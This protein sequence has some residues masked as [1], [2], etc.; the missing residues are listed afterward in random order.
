[1]KKNKP[2]IGMLPLYLQD[3]F[4]DLDKSCKI[5]SSNYCKYKLEFVKGYAMSLCDIGIISYADIKPII[6]YYA[7]VI[8]ERS[9]R[10]LNDKENKKVGDF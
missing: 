3:L 8:F 2:Y 6:D 1:M 5:C 9:M 4:I 7:D 10:L